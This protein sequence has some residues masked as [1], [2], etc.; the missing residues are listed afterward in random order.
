LNKRLKD[1]LNRHHFKLQTSA[2]L[3]QNVTNSTDIHIMFT[4]TPVY[5]RCLQT[6]TLNYDED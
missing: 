1:D 3:A 4:N 5:N 6:C 2:L